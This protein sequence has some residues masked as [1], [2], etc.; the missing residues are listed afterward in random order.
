M[1]CCVSGALISLYLLAEDYLPYRDPVCHGSRWFAC[2]ATEALLGVP[3]LQ[4]FNA[5]LGLL[6]FIALGLIALRLPK[7]PLDAVKPRRGLLWLCNAGLGYALLLRALEFFVSGGVC[8][9]CLGMFLCFLGATICVWFECGASLKRQDVTFLP[10]DFYGANVKL[11]IVLLLVCTIGVCSTRKML[12]NTMLLSKENFYKAGFLP[13]KDAVFSR[14]ESEGTPCLL[15]VYDQRC[16]HCY[17]LSLAIQDAMLKPLIAELPKAS[18]EATDPGA[19]RLMSEMGRLAYPA[20]IVFGPDHQRWGVIV[21]ERTP[22]KL[23]EEL[24]EILHARREQ[25]P[26]AQPEKD[27]ALI[28]ES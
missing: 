27:G 16:G 3:W 12:P 22:E 6:V 20:L 28:H 24:N 13:D 17:Q 7:M 26:G 2:G 25:D 8:P 21:G 1:L 14:A 9:W 4:S 5:A 10:G 19:L 11:T 15:L 18:M 23:K